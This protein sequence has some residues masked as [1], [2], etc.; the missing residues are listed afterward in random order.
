MADLATTGAIGGGDDQ[1]E[2]ADLLLYRLP[3][4]KGE[5]IG[6]P[7]TASKAML[8]CPVV[9]LI[10]TA[11]DPTHGRWGVPAVSADSTTAGRRPSIGPPW[12]A[13]PTWPTASTSG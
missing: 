12:I 10:P 9:S 1:P 2:S 5:P 4:M 6:W 13:S 3:E 7:T 8:P 11:A